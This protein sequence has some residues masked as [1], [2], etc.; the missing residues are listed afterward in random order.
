MCREVLTVA[1]GCCI[2][3][4]N[5]AQEVFIFILSKSPTVL[6]KALE[7]GAV[8][9]TLMKGLQMTIIGAKL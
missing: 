2:S 3:H 5:K 8:C 4:R 1:P 9:G 7:I 6:G